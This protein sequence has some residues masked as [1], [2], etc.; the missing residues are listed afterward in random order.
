VLKFHPSLA[1]GYTLFRF[2][3][4]IISV[5]YLFNTITLEFN[6][7]GINIFFLGLQLTRPTW[8]SHN[9][10]FQYM[11]NTYFIQYKVK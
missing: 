6:L 5:Y 11:P 1:R 10:H 9:L 2:E 8:H 4:S 3:Y 7:Y